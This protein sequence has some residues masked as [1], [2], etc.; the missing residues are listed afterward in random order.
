[1]SREVNDLGHR[2]TAERLRRKVAVAGTPAALTKLWPMTYA[3]LPC[4]TFEE[5]S[6]HYADVIC[7]HADSLTHGANPK[8]ALVKVSTA[9]DLNPLAPDYYYWTAAGASYFLGEYT[10]ALSYLDRMRDAGPASRL[11]AASLWWSTPK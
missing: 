2:S 10:E 9:L 8:A 1:M 11:A 3:R 5:L 7:S 4:T 6:P